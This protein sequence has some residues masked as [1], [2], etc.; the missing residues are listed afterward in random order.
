MGSYE[1]E[2]WGEVNYDKKIPVTKK[3]S[4]RLNFYHLLVSSGRIISNA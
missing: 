1:G 2:G 4:E 3:L